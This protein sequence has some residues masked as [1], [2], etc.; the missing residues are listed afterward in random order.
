MGKQETKGNKMFNF[1]LSREASVRLLAEAIR[2]AVIE[3][4]ADKRYILI[5]P[6]EDADELDQLKVQLEQLAKGEQLNLVVI[7]SPGMR[8]L[9]F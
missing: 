1:G 5:V 8:L 2:E 3:L 7:A 9:E 6:T 4:D